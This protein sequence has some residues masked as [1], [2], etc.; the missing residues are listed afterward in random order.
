MLKL[1]SMINLF[2]HYYWQTK[3][4]I[5]FPIYELNVVKK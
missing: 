1:K 3:V 5:K 4:N 2:F